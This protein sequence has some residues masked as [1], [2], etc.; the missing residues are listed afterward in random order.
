[1]ATKSRA[2]ESAGAAVK[3]AI[4]DPKGGEKGTVEL[5]TELF[6]AKI[7][8]HAMWLAVRSYLINQRQGT[9]KV[10]T[11][12]EVSGGGVKPWRQKGTGRARSGTTRSPIWVGGGRAFG[13]KPRD[14]HTD[15]PKK[16]RRVAFASALSVRAKEGRVTVLSDV[17]VT[18]G[19]TKELYTTLKT[20]GI[21]DQRCLLIVDASES[22]AVRAGRNLPK[23]ETTSPGQVNTYEVLRADQIL[24]TS[25]ALVALKEVRAK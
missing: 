18:A 22:L 16:L 6:S 1:M 5:P 25:K 11:R 8:R 19:K 13:P 3:T 21:V 17:G 2:D 14:Y 15:L 20:L 7:H 23:L 10:K 12:A 9:H 24:V 4:R